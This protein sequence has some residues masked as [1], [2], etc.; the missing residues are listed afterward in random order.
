MI[1]STILIFSGALFVAFL[2]GFTGTMPVINFPLGKG[3]ISLTDEMFIPVPV[4][5]GIGIAFLAIPYARWF[6]LGS[7]LYGLASFTALVGVTI[8]KE[9]KRKE[10]VRRKEL[11]EHSLFQV[12]LPPI[13]RPKTTA[14]FVEKYGIK[15]GL[16]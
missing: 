1:L 3:W 9:R 14:E 10:Q 4:D 12:L 2:H 8:R 7:L 6:G 11:L 16:E 13:G 5:F 15:Q